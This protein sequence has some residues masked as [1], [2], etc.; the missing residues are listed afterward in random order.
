[1][2]KSDRIIATKNVTLYNELKQKETIYLLEDSYEFKYGE[3]VAIL[4][5][6][7]KIVNENTDHPYLYEI[8]YS[9]EGAGCE[10][11]VMDALYAAEMIE[12]IFKQ[13]AI[14][15]VFVCC[16]NSLDLETRILHSM[17]QE[18]KIKL[19]ICYYR[20]LSLLE[21]KQY[22]HCNISKFYMA[23]KYCNY[24]LRGILVFIIGFAKSLY[25]FGSRRGGMGEYSIGTIWLSDA[26]P[27]NIDLL[28]ELSKNENLCIVC[29]SAP[30]AEKFFKEHGLDAVSFNVGR[31]KAGRLVAL[32][33]SYYKE[34]IR[35]Y[36]ICQKQAWSAYG[37]NIKPLISLFFI[38]HLMC[39]IPER[40]VLDCFAVD[41]FSRYRFKVMSSWIGSNTAASR[42]FYMHTRKDKT[43]FWRI[44]STDGTPQK[45][46]LME[47][48]WPD[49]LAYVYFIGN[50]RE[51]HEK[52]Y[53][54]FGWN[55]E[56]V[57]F[58]HTR[59]AIAT[60][61]TRDEY[62]KRFCGEKISVLW[63]PTYP[64]RG[65]YLHESGFV[66]R[67]RKMLCLIPSD[68][69][70]MYVKYHPCVDKAMVEKD[71]RAA[72][73][74]V[75]IDNMQGISGALDMVDVCVTTLSTVIYDCIYNNKPVIILLQ[76]QDP[77][78]LNEK[79][80]EGFLVF[81]SVHEVKDYLENATKD[82]LY[83]LY[84]KERECMEEVLYSDVEDVNYEIA[85]SLAEICR[86]I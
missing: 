39:F 84:V 34:I 71:V 26:K 36:R 83:D 46:D 57:L 38:Q 47:E 68:K 65:P 48:V 44:I 27:N 20:G 29:V 50:D 64:C 60:E 42:I 59:V 82:D 32:I 30:R 62:T 85:K 63:A 72:K 81:Y 52:F 86:S 75:V 12:G 41:F 37:V 74:V 13:N 77:N 11:W 5:N 3:A 45:S 58:D 28:L 25:G 66:D 43:L 1:M 7:N 9:I 19:H 55:G 18:G 61:C 79:I 33:I 78:V 69:L 70:K 80:K 10:Q 22:I 76:A 53:R 4:K 17:E 14:E 73:D 54:N 31:I 23:L 67:N 40:I 24:L 2:I 6:L 21:L 35:L 51:K 15:E 8:G 56:A 16:V 49:M